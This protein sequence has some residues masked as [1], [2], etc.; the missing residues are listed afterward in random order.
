MIS[1]KNKMTNQTDY[2]SYLKIVTFAVNYYGM[3]VI[4]PT[5]VV[6]NLISLYIYTRPKLNKKTNTGFLYGWLCIINV[7][8][9][10]YY[11]F[12]TRGEM[13]FNYK[14]N[15]PCGL[16]NF[17]RRTTLNSITWMQ[18]VICIDRFVFVIYPS[19]TSFM[20]KKVINK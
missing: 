1:G 20:S 15:L 12:V 19:K 14:V 8:N 10:L 16:E 13:L 9:I 17:I 5:C 11:S 18:V 2:S 7:V 3:W 6:G 4:F